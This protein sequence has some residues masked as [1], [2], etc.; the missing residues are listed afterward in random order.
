MS[1]SC[2]LRCVQAY[3]FEMPDAIADV[4]IPDLSETISGQRSGGSWCLIWLPKAIRRQSTTIMEYRKLDLIAEATKGS[5]KI[6]H[7][8]L[9]AEQPRFCKI[10]HYWLQGNFQSHISTPGR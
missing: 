3:L 10:F 4:E 9:N 5:L 1:S 7:A 2:T 8:N 6:T